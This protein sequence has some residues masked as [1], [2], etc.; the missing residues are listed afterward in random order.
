M[1]GYWVDFRYT[2]VLAIAGLGG[3]LGVLFSVP[4]RRSLIVD[5]KLAFPE[6]KAAAEVLR[7]GDKPGEGLKILAEAR[8]LTGLP[9]VTEVV[10]PGDVELVER[11]SPPGEEGFLSFSA[12]GNLYL[13]SAPG[14]KRRV[15]RTSDHSLRLELP[16]KPGIR[17]YPSRRPAQA[18]E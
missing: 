8:D 12:D 9:V 1:L 11:F 5:Q 2:W 4:L 7:T 3:L 13:T 6:G 16:V 17:A 10:S 18:D 15:R 14:T